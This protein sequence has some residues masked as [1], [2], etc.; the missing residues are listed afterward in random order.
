MRIVSAAR[1]SMLLIAGAL[2]ALPAG[3]T[4]EPGSKPKGEAPTGASAS[5]VDQDEASGEPARPPQV[6]EHLLVTGGAEAAHR[7]P[8][9][10]DFL[11]REQL[12]RQ[13]HSDLHRVLRQI[14]GVNIQEEEGYG[15]R[16]NI[17][18][19][20]S[21]VE[22]SQKITLLEDGVLI[23]PAPYAAPA[24]YYVP[25]AGRMES[26]EVRKGSSSIQQGPYTNGG[27]I[28]LVSSSIPGSFGGRINLAAGEDE[29]RRLHANVGQSRERF[30]WLVES[31]HFETDGFKE[32]DDG[33]LTGVDLEDY[34]GK[35]RFN[36]GPS[37]GL[38]QALELK[39]GTT[40]QFG[41]E[42]YL[43]LAREDFTRTPNRRYAASQE[44]FITTD[45]E[46]YQG[47]YT[48]QPN[49][50]LFL[51]ATVYRNDFFRNWHK[52]QSVAGQRLSR[53]LDSPEFFPTELAILRAEIDDLTGALRIRNNRRDYYSKGI[54]VRGDWNPHWGRVEH[55]L[56]FG[57][58]LHE[59]KEDRFQ[60]EELWNMVGGRMALNALG[61]PGSQ[62]NRISSA[63][64]TAYFVRD[65]IVLGKWT[66]SPG[67]RFEGI[68]FERHDFGKAD[69][70]RTGASLV[71]TRN[72]ADAVLPGLGVTYRATASWS[73][74]GGVHKGF[75]PPGPGQG[76]E[77]E[78]EES[79]NYEAGFD[80]RRSALSARVV[81]FFSDYDNLLGRNTLFVGGEGTGDAFNGGEVE[82]RGLEVSARYEFRPW[83]GLTLP[84][85]LSYTYTSAE[86]QSSFETSFPDWAPEVRRGDD[87]PYIPTSQLS[88]G[89]GLAVRKWELY[90]DLSYSDEMRT[91]AGQGPIPSQTAIE[92]FVVVDLSV[93]YRILSKLKAFAQ[94]RNLNDETY[95]VAR[96][97]AGAR[98]GLPRTVL[99]GVSW[100]F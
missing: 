23:A 7:I 50:R 100:D 95:L 86:F 53:V 27:V 39:L 46:Q 63:A 85:R 33:G 68:G 61:T 13:E 57:V 32:L 84:L 21:G 74:F 98:P 80:F 25:T 52:L 28:N 83:S 76:P 19:R 60:D 30:G 99:F 75:A 37:A 42:T 62:S 36:S 45:H 24:A 8:G 59:D 71:V 69:P 26:V 78:N 77:T 2:A 82:V 10:A 35:F 20:G 97:P 18:M 73:L 54:E 87:I 72:E 4:E 49:A 48:V 96:R 43:G 67:V 81:A 65:E 88:L 58:R 44:D 89:L 34:L 90:F 41:N 15:L 14:P 55:R 38:Y 94:V 17:G 5:N 22:R 12:R 6:F 31:Y 29:T 47:R 66:L 56:Q 9:S 79:L 93:N 64:A 3:G 1:W 70:D 40:D 11:G 16:P 92:D 51:T 91:R